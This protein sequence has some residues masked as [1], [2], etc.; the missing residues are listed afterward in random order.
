MRW[1][2]SVGVYG[3]D[4]CVKSLW[5]EGCWFVDEGG[6]EGWRRFW[7]GEVESEMMWLVGCSCVR[8]AALAVWASVRQRQ[9]W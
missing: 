8:G 7:G 3:V 6:C 1:R 2:G 4:G 9:K 5:W